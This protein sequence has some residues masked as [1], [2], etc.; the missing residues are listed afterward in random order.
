MNIFVRNSLWF[1]IFFLSLHQISERTVMQR[2]GECEFPYKDFH[3][4]KKR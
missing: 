1:R 2:L 4:N 3:I